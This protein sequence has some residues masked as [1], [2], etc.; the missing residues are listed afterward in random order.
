MWLL[1]VV[2]WVHNEIAMNHHALEKVVP[3]FRITACH[4]H[5]TKFCSQNCRCFALQPL[6]SP[7]TRMTYAFERR[8]W[9][10]R[11]ET[12]T[13][14][15]NIIYLLL[16]FAIPLVWNLFPSLGRPNTYLHHHPSL[17]L[18]CMA[19]SSLHYIAP[20]LCMFRV[21]QK[22]VDQSILVFVSSRSVHIFSTINL[23][24]NLVILFDEKHWA[25]HFLYICTYTCL[26]QRQS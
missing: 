20:A 16:S 26:E 8:K 12:H 1:L 10:N 7:H 11:T 25:T 6:S 4:I 3:Q 23:R 19:T 5:W 2:H 24:I 21:K 18:R 9:I 14:L 13:R 15:T 22:R 17:F